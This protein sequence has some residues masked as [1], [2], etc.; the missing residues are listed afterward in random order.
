MAERNAQDVRW[1]RGDFER[2]VLAIANFVLIGIT[3]D[4]MLVIGQQ[5]PPLFEIEMT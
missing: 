2:Y 4:L 1:C 3:N 5:L